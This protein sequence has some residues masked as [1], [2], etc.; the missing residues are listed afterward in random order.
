MEGIR[1]GLNEVVSRDLGG[2][3]E[4]NKDKLQSV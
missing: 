2:G 3:T 1:S 4:E